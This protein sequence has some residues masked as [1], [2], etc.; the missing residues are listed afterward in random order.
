M[1][2]TR[3]VA[4]GLSAAGH[5]ASPAPEEAQLVN[6]TILIVFLTEEEPAT[7]WAVDSLVGQLEDGDTLLLLHNGAEDRSF[8]AKYAGLPRVRYFEQRHNLGVAG[9]RNFLLRQSECKE[10]DLVFLVDSDAIVPNDYLRKMTEFISAAPDAGVV[11]PIVL[12]FPHLRERLAAAGFPLGGDDQQ[13]SPVGAAF[14]TEVIRNVVAGQLEQ[15]DLDH[16]GTDPEW[17]K[18]YLSQE[19][20]LEMVL[21]LCDAAPATD[22]YGSLKRDGRSRALLSG[23]PAKLEVSNVAGC[24]RS[25]GE[26]FSTRSA[27]FASCLI[28][29][30]S[31]MSISAFGAYRTGTRTTRRTR[32]IFSIG[33]TSGIPPA[34]RRKS[35]VGHAPTTAGPGRSSNSDG[36]GAIF[37]R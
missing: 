8:A 27:T 19:N 24:C 34:L 17:R 9:G 36:R 14:D 28:R 2:R 1:I 18:T 32:P 6:R 26:A 37:R 22:F 16:I 33:R 21:R 25:S 7:A 35:S 10:A 31:R 12:S 11:G 13:I 4:I 23:G 29:M 5:F 3:R 30:G 15:A 20:F